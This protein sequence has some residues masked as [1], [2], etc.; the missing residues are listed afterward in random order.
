MRRLVFALILSGAT[1]PALADA[2][3]IVAVEAKDQGGLCSLLVRC[4]Q[5]LAAVYLNMSPVGAAPVG[6]S[7]L[8]PGYYSII[9]RKDGYYDLSFG[10]TLKPDTV[11]T[12]LATLELITGFLV[13]R[14][15]PPQTRVSAHGQSY[16][17][18]VIQLPAGTVTV[19]LHAF[20]YLDKIFSVYVPPKLSVFLETSLEPAPFEISGWK[21]SGQSF[22][23]RN[24][25][26]SGRLRVSWKASAPGSAETAVFAPDGS[27]LRLIESPPFTE[28]SQSVAWD[29]TDAEGNPAP[30][31][32]YR[33]VTSARAADGLSGPMAFEGFALLDSGLLPPPSGA[34]LGLAGNA[35]CPEGSVPPEGRLSVGLSVLGAWA[36]DEAPTARVMMDGGFSSGTGWQASIYAGGSAGSSSAG[37][38][39][40]LMPIRGLSAIVDGRIGN[41]E[42]SWLRAGPAITVGSG[43]IAWNLYAAAAVRWDDAPGFRLYGGTGLSL[44]GHRLEASLSASLWTGSPAQYM[45]PE[46]PVD[47]A[48]EVRSYLGHSPLAL[49]LIL[50]AAWINVDWPSDFRAGL[51]LR[52]FLPF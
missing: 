27:L 49:S 4:D 16:P 17:Q 29:G 47:A 3:P 8:E 42:P 1:L 44:R 7:S 35:L 13:V 25:G 40:G 5:K 39:L 50:S 51:G 31:G 10:L 21:L 11:T 9:I 30:D 6:L 46:F 20:G 18:G 32:N 28:V 38:A 24:G 2:P 22:N 52:T 19:T 34:W 36:M 45:M 48:L 37:A 15:D 12:V 14:A 26:P 41:D 23:P 33:I 43:A